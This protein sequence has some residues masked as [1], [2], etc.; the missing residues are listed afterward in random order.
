MSG[1]EHRL[2]LVASFSLLAYVGGLAALFWQR[3]GMHR[4]G[5]P[6]GAP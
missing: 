3:R 2:K 4:P 5:W 1:I 6:R